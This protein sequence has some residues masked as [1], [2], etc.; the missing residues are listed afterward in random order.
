MSVPKQDR[1]HLKIAY[2]FLAILGFW[3]YHQFHNSERIGSNE[4]FG[5]DGNVYIVI[6]VNLDRYLYG[7]RVDKYFF[8]RV[9]PSFIIHYGAKAV[10]FKFQS[11]ADMIQSFYVY[12]CILLVIGIWLFYLIANHFKWD[13]NLRFIGFSAIFLI[14]PIIK[15][16]PYYVPLTDISAM[17]LGILMFY[18]YLKKRSWGVLFCSLLAAFVFPTMIYLGA[19]WFLFPIFKKKKYSPEKNTIVNHLIPA[20][21]LLGFLGIIYYSI[22]VGFQI[23][24]HTNQINYPLLIPS[25]IG[26]AAYLYFVGIA[27]TD[28]KYLMKSFKKQ[29]KP[30]RIIWILILIGLVKLTIDTYASDV[31]HSTN[32]K[33]FLMSISMQSVVN[34]LTYVVSHIIFYGPLIVVLIFIW[35]QFIELIKSRYGIGMFLFV[36]FNLLLAITPESRRLIN[37]WPVFVILICQVLYNYKLSWNFTYIIVGITLFLSRFWFK[38]GVERLAGE[39]MEFPLQRHFMHSGPWMNNQ[40]YYVFTAIAIGLILAVYFLMKKEKMLTAKVAA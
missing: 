4:G 25:I 22:E 14:Y 5:S 10:G 16:F 29:S 31:E 11:R 3:F 6:A 34:P 18:F 21:P 9:L 17:T 28:Y 37:V 40:V 23:P 27:F 36:V 8:Q 38:I 7:H 30:A 39:S 35:K 26:L 24:N 1:T 13:L 20:I 32:F 15:H 33:I 2:I 12:N 19:I